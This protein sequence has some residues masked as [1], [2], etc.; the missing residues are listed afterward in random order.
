MKPISLYRSS[1]ST[2]LG[3]AEKGAT[4]IE[5]LV[6]VLLL[7]FGLV[8]LAGLQ[9][10]G[11]KFNHGAYLRSQGTALASDMLDRMRSSLQGCPTPDSSEPCAFITDLTTAFDG[12]AEQACGEPLP[13]A[14]SASAVDYAASE[15]NQWKSCLEDFLPDGRGGVARLAA[16]VAYVDQCGNSHGAA[17]GP[18]FVVEVSWAESR[19]ATSG[20]NQRDCI[21]MR[22][23]VTP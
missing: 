21:V 6:A 19:L 5:V 18:L 9:Y 8:G 3:R 2:V 17:A 10:N 20:V 23:E 7:S 13:A 15:V 14:A 16:G 12:T 1:H 11:S 22:A 4:L